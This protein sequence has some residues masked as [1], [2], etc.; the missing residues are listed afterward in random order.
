LLRTCDE[1]ESAIQNLEPGNVVDV[2]N[3]SDQLMPYIQWKNVEISAFEINESL[4]AFAG[5][6]CRPE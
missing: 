3:A 5:L 6:K 1:S 2:F 4:K